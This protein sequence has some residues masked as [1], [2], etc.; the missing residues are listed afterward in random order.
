MIDKTTKIRTLVLLNNLIDYV[1]DDE[2]TLEF[3][4]DD[5]NLLLKDKAP[6]FISRLENIRKTLKTDLT[7]L[8][9]GDPAA[10]SL[11]VIILSYPG[12]QAIATYRIA[13]E[14]NSLGFTMMARI[15]SEHAHSRTGIDIHPGATIGEYFFI[16]HGT[17]I[18][19]G[20]TTTIGKNVKLYQGVTLGALSTRG[21]QSLRGKKR[22]P[23]IEDNVTIY[24]NASIL[25]DVTIGENSI[26]GGSVFITDNIA[27]N[28]KVILKDIEYTIK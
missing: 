2:M 25:G 28:S 1:S 18:V 6:L 26:I 9:N 27:P 7:A 24:A 13:H 3:A 20:Q 8:F 16:D 17:G 5:I 4:L 12:Y 11:D 19:V 22:H 14:I 23:T 10:D 15:M 21:G